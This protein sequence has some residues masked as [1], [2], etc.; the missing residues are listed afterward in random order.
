[1]SVMVFKVSSW[2]LECVWEPAHPVYMCLEGPGGGIRLHLLGH[3]VGDAVGV[4]GVCPILWTCFW[5]MEEF[6]YL[7][8][9]FMSEGRR[10]QE[11][12]R[13]IGA[14]ATSLHHGEDRAEHKSE[15]AITF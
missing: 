1:M 5:W 10:Q 11:T 9:L 4:C 12:D 8:F 3:P 6:K 14:A 13:Q 7:G 15:A 2:I